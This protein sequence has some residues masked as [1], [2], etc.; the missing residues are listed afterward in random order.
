M[1][2]PSWGPQS[3]ESL[4]AQRRPPQAQPLPVAR[5]LVLEEVSTGWVG[6]VV[7]L[8]TIG[9]MRVLGLEDRRGKVRAFPLGPGFLYEG[10]PVIAAEPRRREQKSAPRRTRSGSVEVEGFRARTA[11]ASRIWVEGKH[12]AELVAKVWGHD[13]AVEGIVVE[14]LHGVDDLAAAVADFQPGPTRRL[15]ILVDHLVQGSKES[16]IAEQ[17]MRVPSAPGNVL[18][19]GHPYIDIWQAVK[20]SVLGIPAWPHVPRG[21]DWKTGICKGLGWPHANAEDTG[22]AWSRILAKVDTYADLEPALLGRVEE[23]IDFV[24][25]A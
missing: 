3:L 23:L 22:K 9:G 19:L 17:T 5:G 14:P 13:L 10:Q 15:G 11:K 20:P 16:R 8:E 25:V 24:T 4:S 7:S 1:S 12:D 18:I 6:A 21:T 2:G